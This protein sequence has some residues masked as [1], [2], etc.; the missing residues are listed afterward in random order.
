MPALS[1]DLEAEIARL[2]ARA[3]QPVAAASPRGRDPFSFGRVRAASTVLRP[4]TPATVD[5]PP[6][7]VD[8]APAPALPSLS[9]LVELTNGAVTAVISLQGE[10]HYAAEGGIIANRYRI[11]DIR[12]RA[13][14]VVDLVTGTVLHL[15][16]QQ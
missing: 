15:T 1:A 13:V 12:T 11:D 9:A 6:M 8:A 14:D 16:L 3:A 5:D 7:Q 4:R 10:L 2:S